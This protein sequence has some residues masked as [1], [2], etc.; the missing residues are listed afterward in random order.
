MEGDSA[1]PVAHQGGSAV[2]G[3][4][5]TF[6]LLAEQG[7]IDATNNDFVWSPR[8]TSTNETAAQYL[9]NLDWTNGYGVSGLSSTN[10]A[11]ETLSK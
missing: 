9:N 11:A 7:V 8:S 1:F 10:M 3:D 6:G 5:G 2:S 4:M